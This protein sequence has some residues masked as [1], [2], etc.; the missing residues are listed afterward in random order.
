MI[1]FK[2]S[3]SL[4][5]SFAGSLASVMGVLCGERVSTLTARVLTKDSRSCIPLSRS[6]TAK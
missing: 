1:S 4:G 6:T 3:R 2:I 5:D